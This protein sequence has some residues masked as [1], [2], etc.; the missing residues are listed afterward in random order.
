MPRLPIDY[1][2]SIIYKI[3]CKDLD[4]KDCYV[5][6]TTNFTN[7]KNANIKIKL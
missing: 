1:S 5:G 7:R 6:S 3:V 2:K 4:V